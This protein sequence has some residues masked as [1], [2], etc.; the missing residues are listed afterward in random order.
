[1]FNKDD[2]M[3]IEFTKKIGSYELEYVALFNQTK[4]SDDEVKKAIQLHGVGEHPHVIFMSKEQFENVF[5]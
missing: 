4:I 5:Y 2:I 3:K 1:M